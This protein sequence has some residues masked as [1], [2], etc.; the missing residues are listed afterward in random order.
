LRSTIGINDYG[1]LARKALENAGLNRLDDGFNRL[2]IVVRRQAHD[3]IYLAYVDELAK[4]IIGENG[5]FRQ[6]I[7][8]AKF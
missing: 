7:L 1:A 8:R 5:L 2:G 6:F 3:D 4:K